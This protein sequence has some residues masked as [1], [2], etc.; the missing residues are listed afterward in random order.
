M[1]T[2]ARALT[3]AVGLLALPLANGVH[4]QD[5][6]GESGGRY[7]IVQASPDRV[8][9]LD[10]RPGVVSVC[11]LKGDRLVCTAS[12]EAARPPERSYEEL[13]AEERQQAEAEK[14]E[15][16]AILDR[17]IALFR[18]LVAF[19]MSRDGGGAGA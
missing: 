3:L 16:L 14:E 7:Q 19:V 13:Q 15:T 18:E 4:A 2:P 12:S 6:S 5:G 10:T 8:W 9:R 1:R 11:S 17:L